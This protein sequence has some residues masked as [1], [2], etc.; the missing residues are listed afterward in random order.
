MDACLQQVIETLKRESEDMI[1]QTYY[2]LTPAMFM[3]PFDVH[4]DSI[5][6]RVMQNMHH[7]NEGLRSLGIIDS[8]M[9][10]FDVAETL[11]ASLVKYTDKEKFNATDPFPQTERERDDLFWSCIKDVES[12]TFQDWTGLSNIILQTLDQ[13]GAND[14]QHIVLETLFQPKFTPS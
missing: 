11:R 6:Q 1:D 3:T 2:L 5:V 9:R 8:M 14:I 10:T 13:K 4:V 12:V 7:T